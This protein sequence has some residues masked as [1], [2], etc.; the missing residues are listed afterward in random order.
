MNRKIKLIHTKGYIIAVML[1]DGVAI[2]L[3]TTEEAQGVARALWT[4][5]DTGVENIIIEKVSKDE[6]E[7]IY[8]QRHISSSV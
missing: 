3:F 6:L 7:V 2:S 8:N 5:K 1:I 4:L